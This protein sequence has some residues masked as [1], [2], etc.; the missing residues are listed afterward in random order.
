[1]K[2]NKAPGPSGMAAEMF[3]AALG[4]DWLQTLLN[5]FMKPNRLPHK[6]KGNELLE[7]CKQKREELESKRLKS[8]IN[9]TK[10]VVC[11]KTNEKLLATDT[12]GNVLQQTQPFYFGSAWFTSSE[13]AVFRNYLAQLFLD[14]NR[15]VS[16][17]VFFHVHHCFRNPT[18]TLAAFRIR[19]T[20]SLNMERTSG[21]SIT[22]R[23]P[24]FFTHQFRAS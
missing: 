24:P 2:N 5:D 14:N 17:P 6:L 11:D 10:T 1:M 12:S 7:L 23:S 9:K 4:F 22:G 21:L 16:L 19:K 18:H 8:N 3:K 15:P 13:V 20:I